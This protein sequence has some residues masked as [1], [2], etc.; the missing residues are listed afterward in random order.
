MTIKNKYELGFDAVPL[1]MGGM[2]LI[3]DKGKSILA[4][5]TDEDLAKELPNTLLLDI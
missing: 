1:F 2:A 3:G 5:Q 4:T